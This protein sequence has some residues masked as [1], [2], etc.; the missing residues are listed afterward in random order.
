LRWLNRLCAWLGLDDLLERPLEFHTGLTHA[1]FFATSMMRA[2]CSL[3]LE[4]F[5]LIEETSV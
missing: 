5:S 4:R 1:S 3:F 2:N